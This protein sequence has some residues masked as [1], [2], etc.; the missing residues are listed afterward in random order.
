[1]TPEKIKAAERKYWAFIYVVMVPF[2]LLAFYNTELSQWSSNALGA[3]AV[4]VRPRIMAL[5]QLGLNVVLL[6]TAIFVGHRQL[7]ARCPKCNKP[8]YPNNAG[9]VIATKNCPSCGA[10]I[11]SGAGKP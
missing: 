2:L 3:A 6:F 8:I 1:M 7:L 11:I 10:Q 5:V 4:S 9:I